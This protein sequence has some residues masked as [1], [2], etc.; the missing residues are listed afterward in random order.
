[1]LSK[2]KILALI[3]EVLPSPGER[4]PLVSGCGIEWGH[5]L[6]AK[7]GY[8][9]LVLYT[10][11]DLTAANGGDGWRGFDGNDLTL[12]HDAAYAVLEREGALGLFRHIDVRQ[13]AVVV[14]DQDID[15]LFDDPPLPHGG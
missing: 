2:A 1:M 8:G 10:D 5:E 15:R 11:R 9:T 7:H 3:L 13:R 14:E 12:V 6:G 4:K